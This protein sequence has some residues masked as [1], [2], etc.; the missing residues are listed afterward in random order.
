M[1][2]FWMRF[3]A[4]LLTAVLV[5]NIVVLPTLP[6]W[7]DSAPLSA[8]S[9][10]SSLVR[11]VRETR[12]ANGLRVLT[13][14]VK[15]AP[16]VAVQ[17][18][19]RVGSRNEMP[20]ITGISHQLEHMLFKGTESR[21]IQ[22]GRLFAALGSES[23]AFTSYDMTAYVG[24]AASDKVEA[25]LQL[26]A[27]RLANAAIR[28]SDLDSEKTVVLSELDGSNNNPGTRL[29]RAIMKAAYPKNAYGWPVIGFRQDVE[30]YTG[31][32]VRDYYRRFYRP[33]NATLV[34]VGNFDTADLLAKV[35]KTFG[36]I[37][38][39]TTPL[40]PLPSPQQPGRGQTEPVIL[41]EPGSVPFLQMVYVNLPTVVGDDVAALDVLDG[42]LSRGK[43]SRFY[44]GLV[45]TGKATRISGY[46]YNA[47]G[48]GWYYLSATPTPGVSLSELAGLV[49]QEL[50]SVQEKGIDPVEL[51]RVRQQIEA[52]YILSNRSIDSQAQQLGY[53]Q[54]V[55]GDYRLGDRYLAALRRVTV[56]DVQRVARQYLQPEGRV[57]GYFEPSEITAAGGGDVQSVQHESYTPS[58]PVDP[59]EVKRYLPASAFQPS[60]LP[61]LRQPE[62]FTLGNGLQV[63][64]LTDRSTPTVTL[65][66]DVQA[67]TGFDTEARAGLAGLTARNLTSGTR[68]QTA[69]EFARRL[70]E[71]GASLQF[72]PS[73]DGVG[74]G[75]AALAQDLPVVLKQLGAA[76]QGAIFPEEEFRRSQSQALV[77]LKSEL[78][79]PN[80][81]AIRA[82]QSAMYPAGHPYHVMVTPTSLQNIARE[83]LLAFYRQHYRP[84]ATRLAI[85]GDF[86]PAAVKAL[87]T[88]IFANWSATGPKPT[89]TY[90][91]PATRPQ[92]EKIRKL[93]TGKTQAIVMLGSPA[94]ARTDPRFEAAQVL[95]QVLGGDTLSSRL[96]T[97]IRDRQ[98]LSYG[99]YSFFSTAGTGPGHFGIYLQT[100]PKDV[101]RAIDATVALLREVSRQGITAAELAAA[102]RTLLN[103]FPVG[104]A[105]PEDFAE[106]FLAD[107]FYGFAPGHF[108]RLPDRLQAV[109]LADVNR[110]AQELIQPDRLLVVAAT[111]P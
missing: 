48:T 28:D 99:V 49:N 34:V 62:T 71:R 18:W 102:K 40:A 33:D 57:L 67:G 76:L 53:N 101:E 20:G 96:G 84:D 31:A 104:L 43:N 44:Q 29:Y 107:S 30:Q 106:G 50:V 12:L 11:D 7:T 105:D 19:Y 2:A 3:T 56:A 17:V 83:D 8:N 10:A 13:K 87:L 54:A 24:T 39:T 61:P 63:W 6:G 81:V 103:Q 86:E 100:N 68:E 22:F 111:A 98:G 74:F 79:S 45:Q 46:T 23:N 47:I 26:E 88:E 25:L 60:A 58:T 91:A 82:F 95:N 55:G 16:V 77:G 110:V 93:L 32:K 92:S 90:S 52:G 72:S 38:A 5:G 94:I 97:E 41:R 66:G 80:R 85:V 109:T 70:E 4:A 89:L 51:A 37:A 108:Y 21:P 14:E 35:Q 36:A 75:G 65:T 78:D 64:L 69:L 73:R 9:S 59:E 1:M 15:T 42:V 27:D